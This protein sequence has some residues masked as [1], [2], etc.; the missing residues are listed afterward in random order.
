VPEYIPGT[1]EGVGVKP[2]EETKVPRRYR[3]LMHNDDY[4]T[5]EFVVEVLQSVFRMRH[6]DAMRIMLRIHKGGVGICGVYPAQIAEAK[7]ATVHELA[8]SRGY[9]LMCTMEEE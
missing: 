5:M 6:T 3:V 2:R 7:I 8:R 9:P 1:E 4:T